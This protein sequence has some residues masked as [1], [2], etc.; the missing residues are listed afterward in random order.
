MN[1]RNKIDI[2]IYK[3]FKKPKRFKVENR[4]DLNFNFKRKN[5]LGDIL[6][7]NLFKENIFNENL[8]KLNL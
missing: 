4:V 5:V 3:K 8:E 2:I 1:W 7:Y 6:I